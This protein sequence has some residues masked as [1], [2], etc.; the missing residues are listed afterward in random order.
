MKITFRPVAVGLLLV[1]ALAA[2]LFNAASAGGDDYYPPITDRTTLQECGSCHLAFPAA[3]LPAASWQRMMGDL[4]NHFGDDA[5]VDAATAR[6]ISGYLSANAGDTGGARYS[7]KLLRGVS[8]NEAPL[9]I[10]ELPKWARE[11]REVSKREWASKEVGSKANCVA[12][13]VDA[14]KGYFDDD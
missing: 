11:H 4:E 5:S 8:R 10:T 6:Q 14:E 3:M 12:C 13:H 2:L 7:R 1:G 9:R